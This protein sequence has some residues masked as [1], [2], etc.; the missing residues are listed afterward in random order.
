[1]DYIFVFSVIWAIGGTVADEQS[2]ENF[3]KWIR[4]KW[5]K[6][7]DVDLPVEIDGQ[8]ITVFDLCLDY[9]PFAEIKDKLV[10]FQ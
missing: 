5:S 4:F 8:P 3:D 6:V 1:M 2:R 7:S 9:T 10:Q